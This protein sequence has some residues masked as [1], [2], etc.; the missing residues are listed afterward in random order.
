[1]MHP[2]RILVAGAGLGGLVACIAARQAGH[3]ARI[4]EQAREFME[5]GAGIQVGPNAVKAL[6]HLG[7][8]DRLAGIS[9]R[10]RGFVGRSWR[11]GRELYRHAIDR[12]FEE[13]F[14]A[15]YF[16]VHR[17]DLH[18]LL[19][20]ALPPASLEMGVR[21]MGASETRGGA[22]VQLEDGRSL[23]A[24]VV[25][26]ADGIHSCVRAALFGPSDPRFTGVM[27][28]RGQVLTSRLP[29]HLRA[30]ESWHWLGPG[31]SVVHYPIRNGALISYVA[32]RISDAWVEESWAREAQVTEVLEAFRGWHPDVLTLMRESESCFRWG[33]FDREPL[34]SW[35]KGAV[36]LVGDAAH[37]M[38]PFLAQGGAMAMEDGIVLARA[39]EQAPEDLPGALR[40]YERSRIPRTTRVQIGSRER[41]RSLQLNSTWS[42]M[43]RDLG[44]TLDRW[45]GKRTALFGAS[46]IYDY[47]PGRESFA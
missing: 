39:L 5:V 19:R 20:E 42:R 18:C 44:Y 37:P 17:A 31:A 13:T 27:C 25:V 33:L 45:R 4:I 41:A 7:L 21:C 6:R 47:D 35:S 15:P 24:D 32:H 11:S 23:E 2:K 43:R 8:G 1:M 28:W 14:G 36:T 30:P 22:A 9:S 29:S 10:P 40:R 26:G 3:D 16:Q 12:S 38:L 46:W 34:T